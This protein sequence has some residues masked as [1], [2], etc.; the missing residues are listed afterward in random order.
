MIVSDLL[1]GRDWLRFE[2]PFPH[3][4]AP[5]VFKP[6]LAAELEREV[7]NIVA[8]PGGLRHFGWYD[9][10]SVG[11]SPDMPGALSVFISRAW[12]DFIAAFMAVP[13]TGHVN[14][15]IHHHAIGSANGFVHNDLNPVFFDDSEEEIILPSRDRVSYTQGTAFSVG[16][17]PL[18]VVRCTALLYY[19]ANPP[20]RLG[21]G[22]E[23]GLYDVF[24]HHICNARRRIPPINNS[25]LLFNCTPSSFHSFLANRRHPRNCIVMWL[26]AERQEMAK[27]FG[28]RKLVYFPSG[29]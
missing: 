25:M 18:E 6:E 8:G 5:S 2:D 27:R 10:S 11:F 23:T 15:G 20:W 28:Q 14:G 29:R 16:A 22:G 24:N 19:L 13:A 17:R 4:V 7:R 12:H 9:A 21:D 1:F 26:H 3:V